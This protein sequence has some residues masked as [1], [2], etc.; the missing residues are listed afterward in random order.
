[1]VQVGYELMPEMEDS[2]YTLPEEELEKQGIDQLP[3]SL[4]EA[5]EIF[6]ESALMRELLGED[7]QRK[8]AETKALEAQEYKV[9]VT[10]W[11]IERYIDKC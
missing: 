7:L 10:D 3:K 9:A 5:V 8:F 11:E 4:E 1:M 6:R 2:V